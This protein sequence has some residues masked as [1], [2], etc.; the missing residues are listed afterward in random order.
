MPPGAELFREIIVLPGNHDHHLWEA[1]RENQYVQYLGRNSGSP[2][3]EAPWSTTKI[4]MD[5]AGEDRLATELLT[6]VA[7]R[8]PNLREYEILMAYPNFGL[9]REDR[10]IAI[11]H[12]HFIESAYQAMS[13]AISLAFPDHKMPATVYDLEL[14]NAA[15][16][17]FFWSA[18]GSSG[19][20]GQRIEN[21]YEAT[22]DEAALRRIADNLA[23]GIANRYDFPFSGPAWA[24][25]LALQ[26]LLRKIASRGAGSL[27]RQRRER[28]DGL[29]LSGDA[30][31]GLNTYVELLLRAQ[32]EEEH[33][34][35]PASVS[36]VFGHSHKP[37]E[38]AMEF[39]GYA[40]PVAVLNTGGWVVDTLQP[41]SSIGGSA[42]LIDDELNAVNL[43][44][45]N[46]GSYDA[47]VNEV[48]R[49]G[50]PGTGLH[51]QVEALLRSDPAPWRELGI[52]IK[53]EVEL[54][55]RWLAKR[56]QGPR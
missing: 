51:D 56:I 24:K 42:V 26:P 16:I 23:A 49:P 10:C 4:F 45:Y 9:V 28:S 19:E 1:T 47:W 25:R 31:E 15:W 13:T 12:G 38:R 36:F 52:T 17:D 55:E 6:A 46:E 7:R 54:R 27:E 20:I 30:V 2:M 35:V 5:M 32:I 43:R 18:L 34:P 41:D 50:A 14:E 8:L 11:H 22:R 39:S 40:L 3:L 44:F 29:P 21:V 37:F 53:A 48:R 33:G